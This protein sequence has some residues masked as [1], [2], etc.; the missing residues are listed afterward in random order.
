M[1]A[2]MAGIGGATSFPDPRSVVED[3]RVQLREIARV[4]N[5]PRIRRMFTGVIIFEARD[6]QDLVTHFSSDT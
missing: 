6:D 4:F 1:D 2:I 5:R 3:F